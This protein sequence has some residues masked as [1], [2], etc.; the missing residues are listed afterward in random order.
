MREYKGSSIIALPSDYVVIDTET[1]GL[2]Y[3]YCNL[4]ETTAVRYQNGQPTKTFST[5]IK[6]PDYEAY[7]DESNSWHH[8]YVDEFITQLTGITNEMLADAPSEAD[9]IP[10]LLDFLGDSILIGHNVNFDINFI[11]D[12]AERCGRHFSNDFV[13]TL[14][15][16]RK[17][18][19]DLPH[20]RLSDV[21]KACDVKQEGEHRA[22][23]DCNTT[24]RCYEIIRN[25]ILAEESEMEFKSKFL[26][27]S[28]RKSLEQIVATTD[29]IDDT[30]PI[31]GKIVVFTG[32]LSSMER[33]AAYQI[34]LN[35]G[36]IPKDGIT[37]KTN[38]LVVGSDDFASS[39]KNGKTNKMVKAETYRQSGLDITTL[40]E[41]AFFDMISD[42]YNK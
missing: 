8:E 3:D 27:S 4:I 23:Y 36:G 6:P 32:T 18:F 33:K 7:D 2:D 14:R 41:A 1:T 24:A 31:Y 42:F 15:I 28:Y 11:Y 25:R 34:V 29:I 10:G 12:A 9:V 26:G 40:S 19:P 17:V 35:L 22:E 30:N 20:H 16:S 39:V 13:D 5:L 21:A 38:F 37:K